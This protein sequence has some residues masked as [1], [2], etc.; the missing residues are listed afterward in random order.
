M[1]DGDIREPLVEGRNYSVQC[2]LTNVAP[3]QNVQVSWH[4][5][6]KVLKRQTYDLSINFPANTTSDFSLVANRND[7]GAEIWC[8]AKLVFVAAAQTLPAIRSNAV[9]LQV[10]CKFSL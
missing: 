2:V 10:V 4:S 8:E 5:G 3:V 6:N 7:T 1:S 9:K